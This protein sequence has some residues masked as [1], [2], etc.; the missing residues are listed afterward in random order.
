MNKGIVS[1]EDQGPWG[2]RLRTWDSEP[3]TRDTGFRTHDQG[4]CDLGPRIWDPRPKTSRSAT[5]DIE[6]GPLEQFRV[7]NIYSDMLLSRAKD[8]DRR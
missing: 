7:P 8:S 5:L 4:S 3:G 6:T 2:P 1:N